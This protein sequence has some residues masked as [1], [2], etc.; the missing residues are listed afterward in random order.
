MV[1]NEGYALITGASEGLGKH[2]V[3]ECASRNFSII[4]VALPDASLDNLVAFVRYHF[5][6]DIIPIGA[7]LSTEEG[8]RAVF[9]RVKESGVSIRMLINNAG[10]VI[11]QPF[12]EMSY[13][14]CILQMRLNVLG[15]TLMT[16]YFI[17][18]LLAQSQSFLINVSSLSAYF[19]LPNKQMYAATKSFVYSFTRSLQAEYRNKGISITVVCPGGLT[20]NIRSVL[21]N[22][23]GNWIARQSI[24]SPQYVASCAIRACLQRKE[25][26]IPGRLNRLFLML[27]RLL[28]DSIKKSITTAQM[29][30][31]TVKK[32]DHTTSVDKS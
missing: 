23:Q 25:V 31:L 3:I 22:N 10:V 2:F 32:T 7:D 17:N 20:S 30:Q 18:D 19:H 13:E 29:K 9:D 21:A 11:T 24:T 16:K 4:A 6:V 5:S 15:T 27:N 28:P 14:A 1:P 12:H 26:V 8:C